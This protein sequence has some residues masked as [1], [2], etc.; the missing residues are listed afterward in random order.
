[1]PLSRPVQVKL[2]N[3]WGRTEW[4]GD[5]GRRSQRWTPEWRRQ[6]DY[7]DDSGTFWMSYGDFVVHFGTVDVCKVHI[8]AF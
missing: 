4:N 1:M 7:H 5:W 8:P 3:P 6:L 2:R